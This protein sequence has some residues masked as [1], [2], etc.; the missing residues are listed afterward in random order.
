MSGPLPSARPQHSAKDISKKIPFCNKGPRPI[1]LQ[2]YPHSS[3]PAP[4]PHSRQRRSRR[5]GRRSPRHPAS[6]PRPAPP[7]PTPP[8]GGRPRPR[9]AARALWPPPPRRP[10]DA[11]APHRPSAAVPVE[12]RRSPAAV[13]CPRPGRPCREE[14]EGR[15]GRG[16]GEGR[17]EEKEEGEGRRRRRE[18]E[19]EEEGEGRKEEE[20]GE[21]G[22]RRWTSVRRPFTP[23]V[24][25]VRPLRRPRTSPFVHAVVPVP[26]RRKGK[27]SGGVGLGA[28][29]VLTAF[30]P[31]LCMCGPSCPKCGRRAS[32]R[33]FLAGFGNLPVQGRFCRIFQVIVMCFFFCRAGAV[34]GDPEHLGDP[35]HLR[36]RCGRACTA[37]SRH[38]TDSPLRR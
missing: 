28:V 29:Y 9:A 7:R 6:P 22:R 23:F 2:P 15:K 4:A 5:T 20:E 24:D 26:R 10:S 25:D 17:W 30:V 19:E 32:C 31:G 27:G 14:E 18:E 36:R 11:L 34:G 16:G 3:P 8:L 1:L 38:C 35:D 33:L 13:P 12:R 37:S 21:G